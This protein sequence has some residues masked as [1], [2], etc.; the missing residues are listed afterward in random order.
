MFYEIV[1]DSIAVAAPWHGSRHNRG[2]AVDLTLIDLETGVE[3]SMPTPFDVVN[4]Y[5]HVGCTDLSQEVIRNRDMLI[6]IIK[7]YGFTV[8]PYEW[9]HFDFNGWESFELMDISFEDLNK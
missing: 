8:Y 9:W 1:Q 6:N 7:K 3:L 4:D 2:C 5:S